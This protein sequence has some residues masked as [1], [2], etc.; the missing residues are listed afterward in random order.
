LR[1]LG[2]AGQAFF[3]VAFL[4]RSSTCVHEHGGA[5]ETCTTASVTGYG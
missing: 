3:F 5:L 1:A 4:F 2:A